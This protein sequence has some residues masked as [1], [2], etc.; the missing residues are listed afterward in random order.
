MA[1][2]D[3]DQGIGVF[4]FDHVLAKSAQLEMGVADLDEAGWFNRGE[5]H[6]VSDHVAA[7]PGGCGQQQY[8]V[9][10]R[11]HP[12]KGHHLPAEGG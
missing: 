9:D 3:G 11:L 1:L 8:V 5:P 6:H 10:S 2:A 4:L 7:E 12:L